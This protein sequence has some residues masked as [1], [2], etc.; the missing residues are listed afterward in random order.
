MEILKNLVLN[1]SFLMIAAQYLTKPKLI[2][3]IVYERSIGEQKLLKQLGLAL[4]FG[5]LS[6]TSTYMG[7]E[8]K[9]SIVNMRVTGVLASG[10]IGGPSVGILAGLMAGIHRYFYD[11]GGLTSTACAVS[12]CLEGMIGACAFRFL[13]E[14]RWKKEYLFLTGLFAGIMQMT[15][16]AEEVAHVKAYLE[17]E[18]ARFEERLGLH[19]DI[20]GQL[21]CKVPS[22]ILQPIVE[23]AVKHGAMAQPNGVVHFSVKQDGKHIFIVV[24][25][26]GRGISKETIQKYRKN[27]RLYQ[28]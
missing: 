21:K 17:L 14:N 20:A 28:L 3:N 23:N 25:D 13:R 26:N 10:M 6:I 16:I 4:L 2:K 15:M 27:N 1:I 19:I 18:K 9:G 7:V 8:V 5:V 24:K 11:M 12:T 22:F